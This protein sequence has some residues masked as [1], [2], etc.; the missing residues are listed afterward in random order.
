MR[1]VSR[2]QVL[3][4]LIALIQEQINAP[5]YEVDPAHEFVKDM[6]FDDW[7]CVHFIG[8]LERKYG[9]VIKYEAEGGPRLVTLKDAWDFI[10]DTL[11]GQE[12]TVI[13][14]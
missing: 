12:E 6:G 13:I 5:Q 3:R 1:E 14:D 4:D 10:V 11:A 2:N 8:Q 7:N 9:V